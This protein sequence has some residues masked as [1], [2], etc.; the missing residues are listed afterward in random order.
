[1]KGKLRIVLVTFCILIFSGS[2]AM[3]A[4][5]EL[6]VI[7][8]SGTQVDLSWKAVSTEGYDIWQSLNG[9]DWTKIATILLG[10][11]AYSINT[12]IEP[13]K[14]YYFVVSVKDSVYN[15]LTEAT[16][17]NS[18]RFGVAFPPDKDVHDYYLADTNL[19]AN[20]H[21]THQSVGKKLLQFAS[22][23]DTCL[24]CHDGSQ[25]KYNVLEGTVS[26]DGTWSN[27]LESP[28]GS[29]GPL[30]G[31]MATVEP[32]SVHTIGEHVYDAPGGNPAGTGTEWT[33]GLSCASCH[34]PHF[35][36]NYR[37]LTV[38][39][40]D[41]INVSV[42]AFAYTDL[43]KNQEVVSYVYGSDQ[44]CSGCHK[45]YQS[46]S[47]SGHTPATGTYQSNDKFRHGTGIS[48]A[49]MGLQT[50]LPLEGTARDNTDLITCLTCHRAHGSMAVG[51]W[52]KAGDP[53]GGSSLSNYLLRLGNNGTCEDCHNK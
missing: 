35:T 5:S 24:T 21:S 20:C 9:F 50:T 1:M 28:A 52:Y 15:P 12:G 30:L 6:K 36:P 17:A 19:C 41:N 45:D 14:N 38:K 48:P 8:T 23:D 49:S 32:E 31:R 13:Y 43:A 29:F 11:S 22:T 53:D 4:P 18:T 3:G 47:G 42:T 44:L 39:T 10:Q 7:P 34:D 40:P 51:N 33:E 37:L 46:G 27:P 16:T 25:S 26:R 2:I